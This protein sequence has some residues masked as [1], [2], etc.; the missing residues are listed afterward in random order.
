MIPASQRIPEVILDNT[1]MGHGQEQ[2]VCYRGGPGQC[3]HPAGQ[4]LLG[5]EQIAS[6]INQLQLHLAPN[7]DIAAEKMYPWTMLI[8]TCN[9]QTYILT[10]WLLHVT[11]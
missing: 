3:T 8:V 4:G 2:A 9:S 11:M 7:L 6:L 5:G 1:T 10:V